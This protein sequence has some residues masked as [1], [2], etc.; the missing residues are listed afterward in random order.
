M[1]EPIEMIE[2]SYRGLFLRIAEPPATRELIRLRIELPTRELDAHACV[3]RVIDATHGPSG[4]GV[5]FFALTDRDKSDWE[6]FVRD[7][8]LTRRRA[9]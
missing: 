8:I 5:A 4:V 1:P 2:A 3:V 6:E 9:A 7:Q